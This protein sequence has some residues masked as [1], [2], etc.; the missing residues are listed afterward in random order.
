VSR[1]RKHQL[2]AIDAVAVVT[3]AAQAHAA[4]LDLDLDATRAGIDAVLDQ[5]LQH[6]SGTLDDL[7][8]SDLMDELF[9]QDSNRHKGGGRKQ[10]RAQNNRAMAECYCPVPGVP[11]S[12]GFALA[13]TVASLDCARSW[14]TSVPGGGLV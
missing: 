8:R 1:Q 11:G 6:G 7:A 3:H 9:G 4:L 2:V 13:T 12:P 14:A 10:R 5:L